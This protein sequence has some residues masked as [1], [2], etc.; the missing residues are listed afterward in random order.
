[1]AFLTSICREWGRRQEDSA[2]CALTD[3]D[4][5]AVLFLSVFIKHCCDPVAGC[6]EEIAPETE[7]Q[8]QQ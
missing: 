7:A 5:C 2:E 1:M 3:Q 6:A 4:S 8:G